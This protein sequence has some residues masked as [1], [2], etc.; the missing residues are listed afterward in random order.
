[1]KKW[2]KPK[3]K[4]LGL[5]HT[6]ENSFIYDCT[7]EASTKDK[8]RHCPVCGESSSSCN[9]IDWTPVEPSNPIGPSTPM[10]GLS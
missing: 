1:M 10:P 4:S 2:Q 9:H 6:K 3:L 7:V 8:H 5:K